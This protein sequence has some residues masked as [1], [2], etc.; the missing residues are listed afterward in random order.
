MEITSKPGRRRRSVANMDF[1]II[2]FM[3]RAGSVTMEELLSSHDMESTGLYFHEGTTQT[4]VRKYLS[5][6]AFYVKQGGENMM[7]LTRIVQR[8]TTT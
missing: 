8:Q 5:Q 4:V 2:E 1:G 3:N 7:G 6:L